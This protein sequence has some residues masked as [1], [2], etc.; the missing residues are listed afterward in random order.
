MTQALARARE[1]AARARALRAPVYRGNGDKDDALAFLGKELKPW[2][3]QRRTFQEAAAGAYHDA[4]QSKQ[5]ILIV[6]ASAEVGELWADFFDEFVAAGVRAMPRSMR[7]APGFVE[8]YRGALVDAASAPLA[9]A[10]T[11]LELCAGTAESAGAPDLRTRCRARLDKLPGP[12]PLAQVRATRPPDEPARAWIPTTQRGPCVYAG[13]LLIAGDLYANAGDARPI[14]RLTGLRAAEIAA[15]DPAA[16]PD[17]R[18]RVELSWPVRASWW[19]EADATPFELGARVDLVPGHVWLEPGTDVAA[20]SLGGAK[21]VASRDLTDGGRF[22]VQPQ[23]FT[24]TLACRDL[25]L[26]NDTFAPA[27]HDGSWSELVPDQVQLFDAPAGKPIAVVTGGGVTG[28]YAQERKQGFVHVVGEQTFA[29]DGWMPATALGEKGTGIAVDS[30]APYTHVVAAELPLRL[31]S[32]RAAP[33]VATLAKGAYVQLVSTHDAFAEVAIP[34]LQAA[35][36]TKHFFVE[37]PAF[38]AATTDAR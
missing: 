17:G 1:L 29:F 32:Q 36:S 14:A 12:K 23:S 31:E 16:T 9:Q 24:R 13:S 25:R 15:L 38:D 35:N 28:V 33:V 27:Q 22:K 26:A 21:L 4:I 19:L 20:R 30:P 5:P 11:L 3:I 7:D 34:E 2:L 6:Y 37:E 10:R 8:A 18:A